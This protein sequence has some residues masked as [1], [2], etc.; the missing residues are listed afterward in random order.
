[1]RYEYCKLVQF[2]PS[3]LSLIQTLFQLLYKVKQSTGNRW[4]LCINTFSIAACNCLT[5]VIQRHAKQCYNY[6]QRQ[7][8]RHIH[9][10]TI[11]TCIID[12]RENCCVESKLLDY[13]LK[14]H[15]DLIMTIFLLSICLWMANFSLNYI[16]IRLLS[17]IQFSI[18]MWATYRQFLGRMFETP[19]LEGREIT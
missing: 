6:G 2:K 19:V 9:I 17:K 18:I 8:K 10:N 7:T 13:A 1:M 12:K 14:S 4:I 5:S 16:K 11:M 15:I 3:I